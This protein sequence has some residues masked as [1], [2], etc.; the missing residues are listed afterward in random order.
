MFRIW[1]KILTKLLHFIAEMKWDSWLSSDTLCKSQQRYY[2]KS[3]QSFHRMINL[4]YFLRMLDVC[5]KRGLSTQKNEKKYRIIKQSLQI[6]H[7]LITHNSAW[8][9][10]MKI[11]VLVVNKNCHK[12]HSISCLELHFWASDSPSGNR[13]Y[14]PFYRFRKSPLPVE[15]KSKENTVLT[16]QAWSI[17][18]IS[19]IFFSENS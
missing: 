1:N 17:T 7:L 16:E 15:T 12:Y 10:K 4:H 11:F 6:R 13:P 19:L 14:S 2:W 5:M 8:R 18:H 3:P 9:K